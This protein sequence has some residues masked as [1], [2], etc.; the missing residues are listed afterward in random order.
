[1]TEYSA[2]QFFKSMVDFHLDYL[3]N[4]KVQNELICVVATYKRDDKQNLKTYFIQIN[5]MKPVNA[6]K[7]L[8]DKLQPDY[9]IAFNEGWSWKVT[10]DQMAKHTLVDLKKMIPKREILSCYGRSKDGTEKFDKAFEIL[11]LDSRIDLVEIKG[12]TFVSGKLP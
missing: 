10:K 9:Y 5:D 3:K 1:M 2:Q 11:R 12:L 7:P 6:I 8:I 4:L